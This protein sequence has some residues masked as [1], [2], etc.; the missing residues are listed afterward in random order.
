M[1]FK[2]D[3]KILCGG[4]LDTKKIID[5]IEKNGKYYIADFEGVKTLLF[6][7]YMHYDPSK[8]P[9]VNLFDIQ[10]VDPAEHFLAIS[11]LHYLSKIP[12]GQQLQS[13]TKTSDLLAYLSSLSFSYSVS[14]DKIQRLIEK[15]Y[16]NRAVEKDEIE[17]E[18]EDVIKVSPLGRYHIF[19]LIS[20]GYNGFRGAAN[21]IC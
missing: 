5:R 2:E 4:N 21:S 1:K 18:D 16:I 10:H 9:F 19:N 8:S 12:E 3:T 15:S 11:I 13:Y 14:K 6:G 17:D 7:D 20:A